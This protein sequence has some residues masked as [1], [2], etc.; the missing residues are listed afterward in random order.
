MVVNNEKAPR[1]ANKQGKTM[2]YKEGDTRESKHF[3]IFIFNIITDVMDF[4]HTFPISYTIILR[5]IIGCPK[6]APW[7]Q[8]DAFCL[9]SALHINQS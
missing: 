1:Y 4:F 6:W 9:I 7:Q 8:P 5:V 2:I 3:K